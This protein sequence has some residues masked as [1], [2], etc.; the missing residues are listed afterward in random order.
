MSA[1]TLEPMGVILRAP[2]VPQ[3]AP[4]DTDWNQ[5]HSLG[6]LNH[7]RYKALLFGMANGR[8]TKLSNSLVAQARVLEGQHITPSWHPCAGLPRSWRC[9]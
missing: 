2:L 3:P 4:S 9:I 6:R 7:N 5:V 1:M 8:G